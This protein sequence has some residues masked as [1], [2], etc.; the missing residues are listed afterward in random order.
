MSLMNPK[1][2]DSQ[3]GPVLDP[4]FGQCALYG[5]LER[6]FKGNKV[7]GESAMKN[8]YQAGYSKGYWKGA[9][10]RRIVTPT[11]MLAL[12]ITGAGFMFMAMCAFDF[13]RFLP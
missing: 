7:F 2:F 13:F 11:V 9:M 5:D 1:E 6:I 12:L 10:D 4:N 3:K 8:V